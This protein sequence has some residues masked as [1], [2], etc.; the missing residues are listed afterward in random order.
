[1]SQQQISCLLANAFFCTFPHRNDTS[2]GSEY[3]NYP[4]INFSRCYTDHIRLTPLY[5][6]GAA[7]VK[8]NIKSFFL[9][10]CCSLFGSRNDSAKSALQAEKLRAIFQYFDTVTNESPH[11]DSGTKNTIFCCTLQFKSL[12]LP[13]ML[14]SIKNTVKIVIL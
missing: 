1:M 13:R 8:Y 5:Y 12:C 4:T 11:Q 6:T 9:F 14:Y 10:F 7:S 2:P 3:A